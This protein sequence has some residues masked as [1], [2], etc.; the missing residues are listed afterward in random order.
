M[1]VHPTLIKREAEAEPEFSYQSKVTHPEEKSAYEFRV[2]VDQMGNG[3]SYQHH[4]Q[5]DSHMNQRNQMDNHRSQM[6]QYIDSP[7][8]RMNQ[9]DMHRRNQMDSRMNQID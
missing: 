5:M 3:R 7:R 4:Q 2:N 6:N 9:M 8:S 1:A